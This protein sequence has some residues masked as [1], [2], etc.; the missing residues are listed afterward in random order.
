[1]TGRLNEEVSM[2]V[3]ISGA[4]P[5][6]S[7]PITGATA[8]KGGKAQ[9][10]QQD[11]SSEQITNQVTTTSADGSSTTVITYADGTTST[12]TTQGPPAT[13]A[14]KNGQQAQPGQP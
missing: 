13:Q 10:A 5:L 3:S 2:S 14:A 11:Q 8:P 1:M 12:T 6:S 4:S 9:G 7:S